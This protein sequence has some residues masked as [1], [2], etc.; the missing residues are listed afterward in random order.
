MYAIKAGHTVLSTHVARDGYVLIDDGKF[1][2]FTYDE[3][4]DMQIVDYSSKWVAPGYVDVHIHGFIGFD[5]MDANPS[6]LADVSRALAQKGTTSWVPTTLTQTVPQ[7]RTACAAVAEAEQNQRNAAADVRNEAHI[8]GIFLEGPF[9][10]EKHKG[11]QNPAHMINPSI[12]MLEDW[13]KAAHG[14]ICRS[15]LAPEREGSVQYCC[16]APSIGVL[17]ALGHSDATYEQGMACLDAGANSFIHVYNGM[18]GLHHRN[19]GL[20]GCAMSTCNTFGELICD[21]M[22]VN[23]AAIAA[24]VRAKGYEHVPLV[25][26]CL[27]CG[28]MPEGDYMLGDFPIRMQ[29]NL[30]HLILDDGSLGSIAGSVLTLQQAVKNLVNWNIVSAEQAIRMASEVSAKSS[31]IDDVC[32]SILPGRR[33]DFNILD[34][35]MTV[36][37]TYIEGKRI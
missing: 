13:Q 29:D 10:T 14:L 12:E 34:D 18:S 37:A 1:A 22:H 11:A 5:V 31:G 23:P 3:P 27:R 36:C 35:D 17:C 26:D 19:P 6:E 21:G 33:A 4:L 7:I 28:G 30:A 16:D 9:F 20:V 24:V 25:T 32:G 8:E 15:G 2:G